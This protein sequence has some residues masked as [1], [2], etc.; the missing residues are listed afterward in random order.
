M[1]P[2]YRR[3]A[4]FAVRVENNGQLQFGFRKKQ[5]NDIVNVNLCPVL[6]QPLNDLLPSLRELLQNL[7]GRRLVGHIELL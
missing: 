5:S 6:A 1:E 3:C 2:W 7:K 4:R